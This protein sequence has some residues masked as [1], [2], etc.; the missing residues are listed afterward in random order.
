MY[1][2]DASLGYTQSRQLVLSEWAGWW[3]CAS[4]TWAIFALPMLSELAGW[5]HVLQLDGI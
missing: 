4:A 5:R 3:V 1:V 2:E